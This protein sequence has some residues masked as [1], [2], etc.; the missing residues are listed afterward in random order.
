MLGLVLVLLRG[1]GVALHSHALNNLGLGVVLPG[2]VGVLAVL[3]HLLGRE[4]DPLVEQ[5]RPDADARRVRA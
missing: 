3:L 4:L 2:L 1:L 5:P